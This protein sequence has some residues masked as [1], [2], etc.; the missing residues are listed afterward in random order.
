LKPL[1]PYQILA[2]HPAVSLT[3]KY[4]ENTRK[5]EKNTMIVL[6]GVDSVWAKEENQWTVKVGTIALVK[7]DVRA[8]FGMVQVISSAVILTRKSMMH[9]KNGRC[10]V[11]RLVKISKHIKEE[12]ISFLHFQHQQIYIRFETNS[13]KTCWEYQFKHKSMRFPAKNCSICL[14]LFQIEAVI[15]LPN[16]GNPSRSIF[17]MKISRKYA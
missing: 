5:I 4:P 9:D 6:P 14:K 12:K 1:Y 17:D 13:Q 10:G 7:K 11:I 3:W 15:S 8:C 16:F 2:I